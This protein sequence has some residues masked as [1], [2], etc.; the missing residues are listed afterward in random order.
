M[1]DVLAQGRLTK[2]P[3]RRTAKNGSV[4]ALAQISIAA[5]G[6]DG[7]LLASV[8]A[9]RTEAADALL[10]LDKG[11]AVAVAGRAKVGVWQP[12]EGDPRA[13]LSIVAD[14]VLSVYAIRKKRQAAQ[15]DPDASDDPTPAP[16]GE[17]RSERVRTHSG[18]I[19]AQRTL[20]VAG[21]IA[22]MPDDLPDW[23]TR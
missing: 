21:S 12:R 7:S 4:F 19:P 5:D 15:G 6:D 20:A 11:D 16:A 17:R 22:D 3:E 18:G 9:F 14:Q 2:A 13:N 8:I 1:L 10:A 23:G